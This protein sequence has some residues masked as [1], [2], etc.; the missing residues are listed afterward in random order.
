MYNK[1]MER[2]QNKGEINSMK[3]TASYCT[4]F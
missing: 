1:Q 3:Y 2:Q 4:Y